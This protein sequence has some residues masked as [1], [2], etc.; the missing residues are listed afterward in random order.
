M[1]EYEI[2]DL[3]SSGT[4]DMATMFGIYLT[5]VSAY[6][7]V[8]YFAAHKLSLMESVALT[9][10]FVFA[11]GGQALGINNLQIQLSVLLEGLAEI[12]QLNS[13]EENYATNTKA[14]VVAML[15]GVVLS[16][17]FMWSVRYRKGS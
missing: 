7:L 14:W 3:I 8:A 9:M 2:L 4:S 12:R 13:Y 1:T 11:A 5:V 15:I 16:I 10:L 6:L 17:V